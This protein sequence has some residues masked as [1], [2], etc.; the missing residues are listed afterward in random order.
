MIQAL[1]KNMDQNIKH[2][3]NYH[4]AQHI[5]RDVKIIQGNQSNHANKQLI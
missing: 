2:R 1:G 5:Q 3:R 4:I